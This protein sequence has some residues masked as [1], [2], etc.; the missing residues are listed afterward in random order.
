MSK[1]SLIAIAVT[2]LVAS[3]VVAGVALAQTPVPPDRTPGYGPGMMRR[4]DGVMMGGM[5]GM[6]GNLEPGWMHDAMFDAFAEALDLDRATIE[7][8]LAAGETMNAIAE[9]AGLTQDE[10]FA[11]M[12]EARSTAFAQAVEA[13]TLTQEQADAMAARM[14]QMHARMSSGMMRGGMMGNGY[15]PGTCPF[16]NPNP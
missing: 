1:K 4:G 12:T 7:E 5:R 13:G 16:A 10:F 2:V 14:A 6:M 8:R 15:G 3:L 11:I 9:S